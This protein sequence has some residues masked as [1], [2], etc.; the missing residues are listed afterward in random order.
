M[1]I[2]ILHNKIIINSIRPVLLC[3]SQTCDAA[4]RKL[5][6]KCILNILWLTYFMIHLPSSCIF[7]SQEYKKCI[8]TS[9][10]SSKELSDRKVNKM[11]KSFCLLVLVI[12]M[13]LLLLVLW[14]NCLLLMTSIPPNPEATSKWSLFEM[15]KKKHF[16]SG[17][18][19]GL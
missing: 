7:L 4:S 12:N 16:F 14:V 1:L 10:V 8:V 19:L 11:M 9:W 13:F 6:I 18:L 17:V 5:W 3:V 15:V 2:L